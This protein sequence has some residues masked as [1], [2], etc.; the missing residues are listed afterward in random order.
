[1]WLRRKVPGVPATELLPWPDGDYLAAR[2]AEAA[3]KLHRAGVPVSRPNAVVTMA[4]EL[5]RIQEALARVSSIEPGLA[6]R[7]RGVAE[8]CARLGAALP[9]APPRGI[10]GAFHPGHVLVDGARIWLLGLD[11]YRPGDPA[12]DVGTFAGHVLE[13]SLRVLGD[14]EALGGHVE[15]LLERFAELAGGAVR[16]PAHAHTTLTLARLIRPRPP[17]AGHPSVADALIGLCERRLGLEREARHQPAA[18]EPALGVTG[19]TV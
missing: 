2:T 6:Y 9:V 16:A 18:A 11:A 4:A 17:L 15:A 7:A 8:G 14:A 12:S 19:P 1:M 10:H 13:Y 3:R 5:R